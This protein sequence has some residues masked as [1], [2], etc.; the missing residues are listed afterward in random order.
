MCSPDAYVI[1]IG[2]AVILSKAFVDF[3]TS[4]LEN[5]LSHLLLLLTVIFASSIIEKGNDRQ[6]TF[7]FV[8][9]GI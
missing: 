5:P 1:L 8:Y 3:S 6:T 4:G 7:F 9:S 2:L